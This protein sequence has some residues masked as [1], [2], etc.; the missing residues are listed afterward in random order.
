[1][2]KIRILPFIICFLAFCLSIEAKAQNVCLSINPI[3]VSNSN[4]SDSLHLKKTFTT[5]LQC[6]QYVQQMP[7]LLQA[8]G[9]LSASIDS[10]HEQK[11]SVHLFLF[12]GKKYSWNTIHIK[13]ADKDLMAHLNIY[14]D[15][16]K[17]K[18]IDVLLI[19]TMQN[20]LLDYFLTNGY[21]FATISFDSVHLQNNTVDAQLNVKTGIPYKLD[22]I[23]ILGNSKIDLGF[24]YC[25]LDIYPDDFFDNSKLNRINQ[26]L[27]Q[28]TYLQQSRDWS[29][30]MLAGSYVLNLYLQP[31]KSNQINVI[32][33]F[34]PA[35]SQTGGKLLLTGSAD[36]NLKN[37]FGK[38][39]TI[40]LNWQQLQSSSPRLNLIYQ[41]PYLF[42]TRY[43]LDFSFDLYKKDSSYLNLTTKLGFQYLTTPRQIG[44]IALQLFSTNLLSVDTLSIIANK[45]LP[46]VADIS[47]TS[48]MIEH[49]ID[50]TNYKPNPLKGSSYNISLTVGNKKIK[51]NSS[52]TNIT[53]ASFKYATLY[54]SVKLNSYQLKLKTDY[55][56]YFHVSKYAV[57]KTT[58]TAGWQESPSYF[59]NELYQIGGYKLLRGFNEESIYA[60]KFSVATVEYRYLLGLNSYFNTFTDVGFTH[61]SVTRI[62]NNFIGG[63][64]GLAFEAKQGIINVSLAVGKRNDLPFNIN[65]AKIHIGFVSLF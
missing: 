31:K 10:L 63:G 53:D 6:R 14:E 22:S 21:P 64:I 23:R 25:Y 28:L 46:N 13:E 52:I 35:N 54:D 59:T 4:I 3:D 24:L 16:F 7:G 5:L 38:G 33:G 62:N 55:A 8:Q 26:L 57:V 61:N 30:T 29:I 43:G 37:T 9:F 49:K 40:G 2:D 60:N 15:W 45:R 41:K 11:D 42:N 27:Q 58:V 1:M 19:N 36:V 48:I 18:P 12:V 39:E 56:H 47:N 51:K 20:K 44:T 34:L 17:A 50:N 65:E 32:A